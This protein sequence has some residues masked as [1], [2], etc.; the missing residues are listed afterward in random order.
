MEHPSGFEVFQAPNLVCEL[1][2]ALDG[3]KQAPGALFKKLHGALFFFFS[4]FLNSAKSDQ[5]LL[6]RQT[7]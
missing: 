5:S 7:S 2:K 3:P 4:F 1:P 6:V